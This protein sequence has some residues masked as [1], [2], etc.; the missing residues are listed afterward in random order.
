MRLGQEAG[1]GS[2]EARSL[3]VIVVVI[4]VL[5]ANVDDQHDKAHED[6][7]GADDQVGDAQKRVLATH[8]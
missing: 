6:T 3:I 2:W 5:V 4:L 7:E 1:R 8:P